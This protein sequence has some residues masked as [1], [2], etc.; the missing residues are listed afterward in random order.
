MD[1]W[2]FCP[3]YWPIAAIQAITP[4]NKLSVLSTKWSGFLEATFRLPAIIG[5]KDA[6]F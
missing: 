2:A 4:L 5:N 6:Y 1:A 3:H